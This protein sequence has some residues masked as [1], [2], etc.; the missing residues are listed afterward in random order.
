MLLYPSHCHT[1]PCSTHRRYG[2]AK[3]AFESVMAVYREVKVGVCPELADAQSKYAR[4]LCGSQVG[5]IIVCTSVVCTVVTYQL[6][7]VNCHFQNVS[8]YFCCY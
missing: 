6:S 1:L 4:K 7:V 3:A 2:N 5:L 8:L